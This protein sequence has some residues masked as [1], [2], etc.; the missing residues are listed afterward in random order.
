MLQWTPDGG[1]ITLLVPSN[2]GPEPA[3]SRVPGSPII[4]RTR[5]KPT[6]TPTYPFLLRTQHDQQLFKYYTT[7]QLALLRPGQ[8][9]RNLGTPAQ[10]V[11]ISSSPDGQ[12]I[13]VEKVVEPYSFIVSHTNF[14]R[15]PAGPEY[16]WPGP[17]ND[18]QDS[19]AR[20]CI[21][22]PR[23]ESGAR[24]AERSGLASRWKRSE[25]VVVGSEDP[26]GM[27]RG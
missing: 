13:L 3:Q 8:S 22:R 10:Y 18:P 7:S 4:R 20:G 12:N 2:R 26:G 24:L 1:V 16:E 17:L 5:D 11:S 14:A 25:H 9:P 21:A 23:Q 6:P 27:R 15:R 19:V